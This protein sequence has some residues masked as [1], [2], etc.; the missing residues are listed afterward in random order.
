M[1]EV[2]NATLSKLALKP[3]FKWLYSEYSHELA[4]KKQE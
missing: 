2:G 3:I 1:G 4:Y